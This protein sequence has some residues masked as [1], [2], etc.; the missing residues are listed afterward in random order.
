VDP[1]AEGDDPDTGLAPATELAFDE[2]EC[3][4]DDAE[5]ALESLACCPIMAMRLM[6]IGLEPCGASG[7]MSPL[8]L[9]GRDEPLVKLGVRVGTWTSWWSVQF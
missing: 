5:L 8:Q 6:P 7:I 3:A 4:L 1:G 9:A 2:L